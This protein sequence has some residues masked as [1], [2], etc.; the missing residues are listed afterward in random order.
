MRVT[1]EEART[2]RCCASTDPTARCDAD[3]CMGW[4]WMDHDPIVRTSHYNGPEA[5]T[6]DK[7]K[8]PEGEGWVP[9]HKGIER[10]GINSYA[11]D[12]HSRDPKQRKGQCGR[13]GFLS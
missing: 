13:A 10:I 4:R 12:F 5:P 8:P 7:F 11:L 6:L 2:M 3:R 9:G 1:A